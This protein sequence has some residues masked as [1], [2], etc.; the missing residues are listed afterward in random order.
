MN[1]FLTNTLK[2]DFFIENDLIFKKDHIL[3]KALRTPD[4]IRARK[5]YASE[6]N[7]NLR[8]A[9]EFSS[10]ER[11]GVVVDS[12]TDDTCLEEICKKE[13]I[14]TET[15]LDWK[16]DFLDAFK[17]YSEEVL[18]KEKLAL[19]TKELILEEANLDAYDFFKEYIDVKSE[20]NLVIPKG[21]N[22]STYSS[23]T[24]IE[25]IIFLNKLN[26]FRQINK[27]LEHVNSK[28][29]YGGVLMGC[30]ET[31]RSRSKNKKI[32]KIPIIKEVYLLFEFI[33]KRVFPKLPIFKKIYF[34][35]TKGKNRLLSKAESLGRLVSCGFE[36][37]DYKEINGMHYFAARKVKEP[38]FDMSPSYGALFRMKRVGKNGKIIGV[39]KFRTMHPY[40]EYLQ[41]YILNLNGYSETGKPANDFR[42]VPYAK[43]IRRF[44]IDEIPQLINLF[45]GDM[46]LVGCRPVS[47][48][49]FQDIP[50][51]LQDLRLKQKP[52]CI[53]P[54]VALNRGG[55]FDSVLEA[56]KQYFEDK[57]NNPYFTDAK[58]FFMAIY[59][60]IIRNKR[61]A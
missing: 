6:R 26:N 17:L 39:Y 20:K 48:R 35:I 14:S 55:T 32:V 10:L 51:D 41:D 8:K 25:N 56:E 21:E 31:F 12:L 40:S 29:H 33:F 44:W 13:R 23:F 9:D 36:I 11:I 3:R 57:I 49:Y 53:P 7:Y 61:S 58:Y 4:K 22:L 59:N 47:E 16:K 2:S 45:K 38:A 30:F 18:V 54:S 34:S 42:L 15:Y 19:T 46:K 52:G 27:H 50:K 1:N 37:L 28:L 24:A 60:I 43:F 5:T